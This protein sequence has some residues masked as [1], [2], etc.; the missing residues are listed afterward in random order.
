[1]KTW[2]FSSFEQLWSVYKS[3]PNFQK[4]YIIG[5]CISNLTPNGPFVIYYPNPIPY[6]AHPTPWPNNKYQ[7]TTKILLTP[8]L[9]KPPLSQHKSTPST[10]FTPTC[11]IIPCNTQ[12][13]PLLHIIKPHPLSLHLTTTLQ[14]IFITP[15]NYPSNLLVDYLF[16]R[17]NGFQRSR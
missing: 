5:P 15:K 1:M 14:P 4:D 11:L 9:I 13:T 6:P 10:S 8:F 7:P 12:S 17:Q 16:W 3:A 2:Q